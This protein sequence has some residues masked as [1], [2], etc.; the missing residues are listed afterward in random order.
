[1][2]SFTICEQLVP[3]TWDCMS[4]CVGQVGP[5]DPGTFKRCLDGLV[6]APWVTLS[7]L[8]WE[9]NGC[10]TLCLDRVDCTN[11]GVE[12]CL[13]TLDEQDGTLITV[14]NISQPDGTPIPNGQDDDGNWTLPFWGV[15]STDKCSSAIKSFQYSFEA[16]G[17]AT[18]KIVIS[19]EQGSS[20]EYWINKTVKNIECAKKAYKMKIEFGWAALNPSD[21][22]DPEN[23]SCFNDFA[24]SDDPCSVNCI[25]QID[26]CAQDIRNACAPDRPCGTRIIAR[27]GPL[28]FA[29]REIKPTLQNG[30][31]IFEIT[32]VD[33]MR[34]ANE[35][36]YSNT[37]P[38]AGVTDTQ[39]RFKQAVEQL[40]RH[41]TPQMSVRM[42]RL[43]RCQGE[44]FDEM[45]FW[46]PPNHPHPIKISVATNTPC[47]PGR[48]GPCDTL[49][50][51]CL[52]ACIYR[53]CTM[54]N[55]PDAVP[56]RP[57]PDMFNATDGPIDSWRCNN[58]GLYDIL[59]EWTAHVRADDGSCEGKKYGKGIVL[60]WDNRCPTA[61]ILMWA[62]PFPTCKPDDAF[63]RCI[64]TYI[65]NGGK[66]VSP[67]TTILC[68]KGWTQIQ[69]IFKNKYNGKVACVDENGNLVW[70]NVV[71]WY[72]N[73]L[74][75]RKLIKVH[76][77][78]GRTTNAGVSG[79]IF[80]H[81]HTVLTNEGY[82]EVGK[83]D[84]TKHTIHSG[85]MCPSRSV[86]Q[87]IIGTMFGDS[88]VR[89]KSNAYDCGHSDKQ[90]E[91]IKHKASILGLSRL[92]NKK[93]KNKNGQT[94][95]S[96]R[97][98]GIASPYWRQM[99]K[100]FYPD[101][102]Q[103]TNDT[104]KDFTTISLAYLFMDD[105]HLNKRTNASEIATCCYS[106]EEV[107]LLIDKI[108]QLSI[109]GYRRPNSKYS[110]ITFST[111]ETKK[112]SKAIAP[113]VIPSMN[114][115]LIPEHRSIPK[116]LVEFGEQPFYDTFNLIRC[117]E[118]ER[119]TKWV[120][121]IDVEGHHNFVTHSGVAHNCSPVIKFEPDMKWI[122]NAAMKSGGS[123]TPSVGTAAS[124]NNS[125]PRGGQNQPVPC[126][127]S[128][129]RMNRNM[130]NVPS[131]AIAR[132]G[133]ALRE[134]ISAT[135]ANTRTNAIQG[136]LPV[137]ATLVV[138][139]DPTMGSVYEAIGKTIGLVVI[140]PFFIRDE[141]DVL[142]FQK[143][144][145][146]PYWDTLVRQNGN[147]GLTQ[148]VVNEVLTNRNW[149]I[150]GVS[151]SIKEGS[152]QTTYKIY[153]PVPGA[154]IS[155]DLPFGGSEDGYNPEPIGC[156]SQPGQNPDGNECNPDPFCE[157]WNCVPDCCNPDLSNGPDDYCGGVDE[158]G[159]YWN[160][161]CAPQ[162]PALPQCNI[163]NPC[164]GQ[165][166]CLEDL[167]ER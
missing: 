64:G 63:K 122:F 127:V 105:G 82:I 107:D 117:E 73:K 119:K 42:L 129:G 4:S 61:R 85:T 21:L 52:P 149:Y 48:D 96:I 94:Y 123:M 159:H 106:K 158:N 143:T 164:R 33:L 39:I 130:P 134:T 121:C 147:S 141:D 14:G 5:T 9:G 80:T 34:M 49:G 92:K 76:L 68:D 109:E 40:V 23:T 3:R 144:P 46:V 101:G 20:F 148:Q 10:P 78:N 65:V 79:A 47:F 91:Y 62:D 57:C 16:T 7:F 115:K 153:L 22:S 24:T 140:N 70:S 128:G 135:A 32:G 90:E 146:C 163:P 118:L 53:D 120:Y 108:K 124:M 18:C 19:D 37:F 45:E 84:I 88:S 51:E 27:S 30:R 133:E 60:N 17:G 110:R 116:T 74:N 126:Q 125:G 114:Y 87:A 156:F 166:A 103:I 25:P 83:L 112:L 35:Q 56:P 150:K 161:N 138:Q 86:H 1:M 167:F 95:Q 136:M 139:G 102:K 113:Y 11:C 13:Q 89:A 98:T 151:H 100:R 50:D 71:N 12:T 67:Y 26:Y 137:E 145:G 29:P 69:N 43:P 28:Y 72:R 154:D 132:G 75:D 155:S 6:L 55:E 36:T 38:A 142:P 97:L 77:H 2:S 41:A 31:F 160:P 104:L 165:D 111:E 66:C 8:D 99:R 93:V 59:K 152:F 58:K 81:D 15:D 131:G 44:D 162:T 54:P 157:G